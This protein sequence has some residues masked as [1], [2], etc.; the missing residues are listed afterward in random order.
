MSRKPLDKGR[1]AFV[2]EKYPSGPNQMKN[3][4]AYVGRATK[5][6]GENGGENIEIELDSIPIGQA[7]PVKFYVFWDSADKQ[8]GDEYNQQYNQ[9]PA[10]PAYQHPSSQNGQHGY[11]YGSG[12]MMDHA[13][14]QRFFNAGIGPWPRGTVPPVLPNGY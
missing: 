7:G 13:T 5:W 14:A 6:P 4:Y 2:A 3:R 9:Q 1:V 12:E 8:G 11:F 10:Q